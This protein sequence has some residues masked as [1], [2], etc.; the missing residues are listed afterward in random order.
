TVVALTA[1][2]VTSFLAKVSP[3]GNLLWVNNVAQD[4]PATGQ[5]G[6]LRVTADA[7]GN[8]AVLGS[9]GSSLV[10]NGVTYA[11]TTGLLHNLVVRY[12]AAGTPVG[13]FAAYTVAGSPSGST[14]D[15]EY[16]GLG[17]TSTG[18][19]YLGGWVRPAATLQFGTLSALTGPTTANS[20]GFVVKI[21]AANTAA[22]LLSTAGPARQNASSPAGQFI[23]GLMVGPQDQC[24]TVGG[25]YGSTMTLGSQA[26]ATGNAAAATG[27]D[28]FV[29]RIAPGGTIGSLVGG[30]G[31]DKIWGCAL[32]PQGEVTISTGGG[33]SWGNVQLPGAVWPSSTRTGLVQL[34]ATG[35]PQRG[36]Q[37]GLGFFAPL[38][39]VDGLNR[40]ILAGTDSGPNPF[41]FGTR[42]LASPYAWNT[43]IARTATVLLAARQAA[44]VAG[45]EVYPNP[46]HN[47]VEV[48]MAKAQAAR[49]Q[50]SDALGR[51]VR[52]QDLALG[53]TQVDLTGLA[54]GCY[55]LL[56][57]Q[58]QARSFRQV[59]V[60]P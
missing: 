24:Y 43:L 26:L 15:Y 38:M 49:I 32:G 4:A 25:L 30:G 5:I 3:T 7:V 58:D 19:L 1:N 42:Q 2:S 16:T 20:A 21:N 50:L 27:R 40:P 10:F 54:P 35:V 13:A 48:H 28:M 31:T 59:V 12:D 17:L 33:L 51:L 55:T 39:A 37:A 57:Q 41:T 6:L 9:F 11:G 8:C 52:T 14:R 44:Q 23:T 34:D 60:A 45:L 22:W 56:V 36:W 18:E 46:A 47:L 29:A 53:Q